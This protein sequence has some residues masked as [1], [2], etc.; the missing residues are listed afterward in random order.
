MV[1]LSLGGNEGF[2]PAPLVWK[3]WQFDKLLLSAL[4]QG[5][6]EISGINCACVCKLKRSLVLKEG[7]LALALESL[8]P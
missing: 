7:V 1:K 8:G 3:Q 5:K 6:P 2:I 4:T